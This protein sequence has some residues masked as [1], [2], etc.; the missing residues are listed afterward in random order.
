MHLAMEYLVMEYLVVEAG[1]DVKLIHRAVP[2]DG[3]LRDV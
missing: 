1:T 2:V 3:G